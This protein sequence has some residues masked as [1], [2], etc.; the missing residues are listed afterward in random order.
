MATHPLEHV[1][2]NYLCLEPGK[3]LEENV[4]LVTDHFTQYAQAYVTWSQTAQTTAKALWD[5]FTIHYELPKKIL[6]DQGRNIKSQLV[7]DLCKL[8]ETQ[9]IWTSPYHPLISGQ[10]ERFYSTL[11]GMLGTFTPARKSG[12]KKHIGAL[13]H[14]YNCSQNSATGFSLYY[15]MYGR[16]PHLPVDVTLGLVLHS[17]MAPTTS[18]FVQKL[19]ECI[20][21]AHKRATLLQT[22]EAWH[23]KLKFDKHNRAAAWEVEDTVLVHVT[24]FKGHHKI[25]DWWENKE[26]VVEKWPYPNV[27]VY[28]VCPRDGECSWTLHRNYLLPIRPNLEQTEDDTPVAV[29]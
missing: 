16:Q 27:P 10:F 28:V 2:L 19:R 3:G 6:S 14:A 18:K 7:A 29:V 17:V 22:K 15:L 25:Q 11:I 9:K 20:Q 1:H 24:A 12:W 13:V 5:N 4:L 26:Y 23:H 21:W 8:M